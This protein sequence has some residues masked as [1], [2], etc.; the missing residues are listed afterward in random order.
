MT[1][2]KRRATIP[3]HFVPKRC[4]QCDS[5]L[6][7]WLE[8]DDWNQYTCSNPNTPHR[9]W[10]Q[11]KPAAC[12]ILVDEYGVTYLVVRAI[13]PAIG[14]KCF[15]GGHSDYGEVAEET[16]VHET[17][18][19]ACARI[20]GRKPIY[21]GQWFIEGPGVAQS[22]YLVLILRADL[23]TF[24]P[25]FEASDRIAA[26]FWTMDPDMLAFSAQKLAL[27]A[28]RER[29]RREAAWIA[30]NRMLD[31][32]KALRNRIRKTLLRLAS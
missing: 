19:E 8:T 28:A 16:I 15:P 22:A 25:N 18:H 26:N 6:R 32:G 20:Y 4:D 3:D 12:A 13:P 21:L 14:G 17:L 5:P 2:A 29:L 23:D 24:V 31:A 30:F 7:E 9:R 27:A 11:S 10:I 1:K